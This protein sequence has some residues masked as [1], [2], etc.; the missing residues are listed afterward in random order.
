MLKSEMANDKHKTKLK[1]FFNFGRDQYFF[2]DNPLCCNH[3]RNT[4]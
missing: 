3:G 4:T 1:E 2:F